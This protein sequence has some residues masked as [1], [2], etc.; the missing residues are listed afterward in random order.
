MFGIKKI[1]KRFVT[2]LPI[3]A[4]VG[5]SFFPMRIGAQQVL[6]LFTLIWFY[7]FMLFEVF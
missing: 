4:I 5:A 7:V 1:L 2:G 3:V 6:V